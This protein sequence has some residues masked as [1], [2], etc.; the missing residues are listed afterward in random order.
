MEA[1]L[2]AM[3]PVTCEPRMVPVIEAALPEMLPFTCEPRIV[4]VMDAD[5]R[6]CCRRLASRECP[7]REERDFAVTGAGDGGPVA[8]CCDNAGVADGVANDADASA[9]VERVGDGCAGERLAADEIDEAGAV[10]R[11][12]SRDSECN[13]ASRCKLQI[14]KRLIDW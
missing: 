8:S 9:R 14:A 10:D 4:P 3:S 6:K 13:R 1:A 12:A 11:Q 5:S 7:D 2:P